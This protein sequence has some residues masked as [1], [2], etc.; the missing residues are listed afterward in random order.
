MSKIKDIEYR[1][2][3]LNALIGIKNSIHLLSII[4]IRDV[5]KSIVLSDFDKADYYINKLIEINKC[6][7]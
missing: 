4:D 2:H 3:L 1:K 5:Q 7:F 6:K